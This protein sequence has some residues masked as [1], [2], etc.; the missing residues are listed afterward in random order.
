MVPEIPTSAEFP[1][2]PRDAEGP[3][4]REPWEAKAFAMAVRLAEEG[5]FTWAE[6]TQAL[7]QEIAAV[8]AAG[9]P[10]F[11][12]KYYVYWLRALE[13]LIARKRE[14]TGLDIEG[15]ANEWRAAYIST[16]HGQPIELS[17][18]GKA[19]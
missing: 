8:Q 14:I 18:A 19:R 4:F 15:R 2:I 16:P 13:A 1:A 17:A 9:E 12:G 3:V 10:D 6:W 11:G 5:V 7:S